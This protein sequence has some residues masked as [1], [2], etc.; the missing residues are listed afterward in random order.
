MMDNYQKFIHLSRYARWI[1]ELN[2]RETWDETVGRY[3]SFFTT[4]FGGVFPDRELT[5]AISSLAVVPSMRAMMTAGEALARDNVAAFNCSFLAMN[6]PR[7]FDELMYILMCGTGVGFSV[8]SKY[9]NQLPVISEEFHDSGTTVVVP[10]S[11]IGWA[12]S[13]REVLSL[14]YSGRIPKYDLSRVRPAGSKLRVFGGRA[15]GPGP[16]KGLFDYSARLF[17]TAA[18]RKL[19]TIEVHDLVCR[20]A[21]VVIV[22]GVRRSALISL[23]ELNDPRMAHAKDGQWWIE[24]PERALANNSAVYTEKP[25]FNTFL[26]E[27]QTLYES[28]SGE[29]GIFNRVAT[30]LQA[31]MSGR[32]EVEGWDFGTNPC[33]EIILRPNG[34]CNLTEVIVSSRDT[35]ATLKQKIKWAAI[36]GTFQS[37]LTDFRYLRK[38]WKQNAEEERLLGVSLTGIYDNPITYNPDLSFLK[39]LKDIAVET[40]KQWASKIGINPSAAITCIKPSGT[41]SQLA[42]CSSGI[43]PAYSSYYIRAV[44]LDN[45][46]P[47]CSFLKDSGVRSEPELGHPDSQTVF[48]FPRKSSGVTRDRITA[49]SHLDLYKKYRYNYCEH[50]PSITV[51][52]SDDEFL[53]VGNWVWENYDNI[54]GIAFLPRNDHVY[55]QA[56]Y[57]EITE[58]EYNQLVKE[59]PE[60]NFEKFYEY[61]KEDTTTGTQE[62]A[63]TAGI[64]EV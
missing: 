38:T 9:V 20:I 5:Q 6:H 64:C 28:K 2:R 12:S 24:N 51:Y 13:F 53:K 40:N 17:T 54:G 39:E 33:G 32:R 60:L 44:R 56:P 30:K 59:Q 19:S 63:C 15:S 7:A 50:N 4:R 25:D 16:L 62:L 42:S 61:E 55:K 10:D 29:R 48:Y 8:E 31:E 52:Y 49:L 47:I 57:T 46:D 23:S 45:K 36:L 3:I 58:E 26:R 14:L 1:P 34:L 22:G 37:T 43:H 18:G 41:V 11:R 21:D 27:W 35:Q